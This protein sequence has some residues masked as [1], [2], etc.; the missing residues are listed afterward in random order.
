VLKE[1]NLVKDTLELEYWK[2]ARAA[3]KID[4]LHKRQQELE[5]ELSWLES[6]QIF[7]VKAGG[8]HARYEKDYGEQ[9]MQI[10][11]LNV[12]KVKLRSHVIQESAQDKK[13]DSK[14]VS[15]LRGGSSKSKR[16]LKK[17]EVHEI[18]HDDRRE[19]VGDGP[20]ERNDRTLGD[21]D[22]ELMQD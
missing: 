17:K 7:N 21:D 13:D 15:M 8:D 20:R 6:K 9:S 2:R 11:D 18:F 4:A 1:I 16:K 22:D 5:Q 12:S 10:E 14:I 19:R 3:D